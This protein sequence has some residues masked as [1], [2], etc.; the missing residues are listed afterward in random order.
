MKM[1]LK[2]KAF[3]LI[4]VLLIFGGLVMYLQPNNP[5]TE[6]G[7]KVAVDYI[8]TFDNGEVFDTSKEL[9][10]RQ[11]NLF[12]PEREYQPLEFT[13]GAGEMIKGFDDAVIGMKEGGTRN[14]QIQPQDAY[15]D[16]RKDLIV[17]VNASDI[18][19]GGEPLRVGSPIILSNGAR[20]VVTKIADG[21]STVD[22]NHPM[23]GK[24]LNFEI[25][26]VKIIN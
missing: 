14:I 20:G 5:K 24:N 26:L 10:A 7:D 23:A 17:T 25:T 3:S 18:E 13:V 22:F 11:N 19:T 2:N 1:V 21:K 8:G 6:I 12:N 16:I 9:V 4:V 15:G